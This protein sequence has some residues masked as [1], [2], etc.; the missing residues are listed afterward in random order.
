MDQLA[1]DMIQCKADGYGCHYGA[2]HAAVKEPQMEAPVE[3]YP[4][5][6]SDRPR[7]VVCGAE[8]PEGSKRTITCGPVC[9][10]TRSSQQN[11][12]QLKRRRQE[13]LQAEE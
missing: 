6:K 13:K 7:C 1:K 5:S 3:R 8:I 2:W 9:A 10:A 12:E 4:K 11:R